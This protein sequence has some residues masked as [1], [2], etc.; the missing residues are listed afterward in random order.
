MFLI[1]IIFSFFR[2]KFLLLHT[3]VVIHSIFYAELVLVTG[4]FVSLFSDHSP[5]PQV[6]CVII[7]FEFVFNS[8]TLT[9]FFSMTVLECINGIVAQQSKFRHQ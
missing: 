3:L 1:L 5:P 2:N 8:P 6:P 4:I 7:I 9:K